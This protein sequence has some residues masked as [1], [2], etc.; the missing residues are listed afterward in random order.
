LPAVSPAILPTPRTPLVGRTAELTAA[1]G[2]LLDDAV[3]LLTL[4]GPGGVGKTR[5][6][7]AIALDVAGSFADGV[8]FVDLSP[9]RDP[10]LVLPT[11]AATLGVREGSDVTLAGQLAAALHARQFLLVLDNC[12]QVL[13]A[14]PGVASL[15]AACPALQILASS[16]APLRVRGEHLLSVPPLALPGPTDARSPAD[17]GQI[18]AIALFVARARAADRSFALGTENAAAV[19]EICAR[20]DGLPLAIE[21]AAARLRAL[22]VFALLGLLSHRLRLLTGGERDRP[23]RQRTLR[24]AVAWSYNLLATDE[25]ALVRRL[26][27]FA[28]GFDAESAATVC[29]DDPHVICDRI[30]ALADQ[31]LVRRIESPAGADRWGMLETIR[32]FGLEHLAASGE[33]AAVR[34][35]HL[36]WCIATVEA[37][38]PPRSA[39]LPDDDALLRLDAARDNLRSAL[40]WAIEQEATDAALR[41]VRGLT[42]YWWLRG[43]FT[44]GRA[45]AERTLALPGGT[46]AL[47]AAAL[48]CV[49][50]LAAYQGEVALARER[51]ALSLNL[52]E[53]HGD[54]LDVLR[55]RQV[56]GETILA[57][58]DPA[59]AVTYMEE[60][61]ALA[62]RVGD[63]GW[64]APVTNVLGVAVAILGDT[65]R[66]ATL[67]A[68]ALRISTAEGDRNGEVHASG[69]LAAA[70]HDLGDL[71]EGDRLY[72]RAIEL[73]RHIGNPWIIV[74]Y[75]I[76]LAG[77][78]ADRGEPVAAARLLGLAHGLGEPLGL[79]REPG[80]RRRSDRAEAR[81]HHRLDPDTFAAAWNAGRA[82]ARDRTP[83]AAL[84]VVYDPITLRPRQEVPTSAA[85]T[86]MPATSAAGFGLSKRERE[87][88][89]LLAQRYTDPE[90]AAALS[91]AIRTA[92]NHV[93]HIFNK[94]GVS[95]RR[96]A[97][98]LAA[99]HGLA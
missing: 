29:G 50:A 44:E 60:T 46:P 70:L 6:A 67:H 98:A 64:L 17:L 89:A 77:L 45:W 21:L 40:A 42:E 16:R 3:P 65:A 13:P 54:S 84:D 1:R 69:C 39:A 57:A 22:S 90:I 49:S 74:A 91:I 76:G 27:V 28:G 14:A 95:S 51:A 41:L 4:T 48:F 32:E 86:P 83:T 92:N 88:L 82:L 12:E 30:T 55:A 68:A 73:A 66:A 25:Q 94:L 24:D 99:R 58:A 15:L 9:I 61:L 5:L 97:A 18:A 35:R 34:D 52:A 20:L 78:T 36:A 38:W 8:A 33:E 31:S 47:R 80:V 37:A 87:V 72:R 79:M 93:T 53:A 96:E 11:I 26:A 19:A 71:D 62:W 10:D 59:D 56:I 23:D 7:L 85:T 63:L 2:L 43:D 75:L 81:V